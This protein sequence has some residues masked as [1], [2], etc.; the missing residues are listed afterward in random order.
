VTTREIDL[1]RQRES[2]K[3]SMA[4]FELAVNLWSEIGLNF[5]SLK[6]KGQ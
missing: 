4:S 2:L 5:P 3:V 1:P 6:N